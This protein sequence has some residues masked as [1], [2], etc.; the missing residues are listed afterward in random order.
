MVVV[1]VVVVV[2]GDSVVGTAEGSVVA[3]VG[4]VLVI[5]GAVVPV[6]SG[7]V[8]AHPAASP[9]FLHCP[10][11]A[12]LPLGALGRRAGRSFASRVSARLVR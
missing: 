6:G 7:L 12:V 5:V 10:V 2:A 4:T 3:V 11:G 8:L 1:V 9:V